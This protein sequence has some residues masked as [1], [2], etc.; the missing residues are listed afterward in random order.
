[1][2][3]PATPN[4]PDRPKRRSWPAIAAVAVVLVA[5]ALLGL[6]R[7]TWQAPTWWADPAPELEQT[8][9]LAD[10]VEYRL[11]E[12]A[13]KV[14]PDD[15]RWWLRIKD[16][17]V[18]AWLATR[19]QA[20]LAHTHGVV[21]P[22]ALGT[23]QVHFTDG[24]INVALDFEDDGRRRY[25]VADLAPGIVDGRLAVVLDGVA[26]GRL[27][28][29]GGSLRTLMKTYRDVVP[30]GFL[31]DPSVRRVVDL[32]VDVDSIDPTLTLADDRRVRVVD[33]VVREGELILRCETTLAGNATEQ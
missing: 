9:V 30:A 32:L 8:S 5:V 3:P 12:E 6:R 4:A 22:E 27:R 2:Q 29:P 17:Q 21:W 20:W 33:L 25:V 13:H 7:L 1:M 31:D 11:A 16:E 14:R 23:P 28:I 26:L 18:N 19:L 24:A 15:G 10:R